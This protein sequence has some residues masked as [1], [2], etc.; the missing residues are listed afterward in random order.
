MLFSHKPNAVLYILSHTLV[1]Y[2]HGQKPITLTLPPE[3]FQYLEIQN[4][5]AALHLLQEFFHQYS[6]KNYRIILVLSD[7]SIFDA[8]LQLDEHTDQAVQEFMSSIPFNPQALAA[9]SSRQHS[10]QI[11][12][13][14]NKLWVQMIRSVL[15]TAGNEV[16]HVLPI[17][18][19]GLANSK[20]L[21]PSI[22]QQLLSPNRATLTFDFLPLI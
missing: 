16:I 1:W 6:I 9:I 4:S 11:V 5:T 10:N 20:K 14:I 13:A 2:A 8:A 21:T 15:V 12:V 3:A 7:D 19:Y 22:L 17:G 18:G